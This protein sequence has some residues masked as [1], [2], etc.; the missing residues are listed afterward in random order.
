MFVVITY[1][2]LNREAP[3]ISALTSQFKRDGISAIVLHQQHLV[4]ILRFLPKCF[5]IFKS[6]D[7]GRLPWYKLAK[8]YLHTVSC[9]DSEGLF[10]HPKDFTKVRISSDVYELLDIYF[11]CGV[12]QK[13]LLTNAPSFDASK[14]L[15]VGSPSIDFLKSLNIF[16]RG[17]PKF[18]IGILT[19]FG[20]YNH[21][22][23]HDYRLLVQSIKNTPFTKQE[24]SDINEY[25][26]TARRALFEYVD[27]VSNICKK[28]SQLKILIRVH[29]SEC[30]K[31]WKCLEEQFPQQISVD[32]TG[33]IFEFLNKTNLIVSFKSTVSL[34]ALALKKPIISYAPS[35]IDPNN[36]FYPNNEPSNLSLLVT[37]RSDLFSYIDA[38]VSNEYKTIS[39]P[40]PPSALQT[41]DS[42]CEGFSSCTYSSVTYLVSYIT[43]HFQPSR[44]SI[45]NRILLCYISVLCF[46]S[47][48]FLI[49]R[50]P[51]S[52]LLYGRS[53]IG[54]RLKLAGL[55]PDKSNPFSLILA[56]VTRTIIT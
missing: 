19:G 26:D 34:E 41:A 48:V 10:V 8:K 29:P 14:S 25:I 30:P 46:F 43:E 15:V 9:F 50:R 7:H 22:G 28:Y 45:I 27:L 37:E 42:I 2:I 44:L 13:G 21:R 56:F 52:Y 32:S 53:K 12:Y 4:P 3:F 49:V 51:K 31:R 1:E 35:S 17:V 5:I 20:G 23:G 11:I 39:L 18:D 16:E 55:S 47:H 38:I 40:T 6:A 54:S 33:T 36:I 24:L